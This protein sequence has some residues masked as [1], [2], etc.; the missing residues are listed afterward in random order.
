MLT[1]LIGFGA[2]CDQCWI[3][4]GVVKLEEVSPDR[5]K[6]RLWRA[7]RARHTPWDAPEG[8]LQEACWSG[9]SRVGVWRQRK[10]ARGELWNSCF[11]ARASAQPSSGEIPPG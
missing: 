10:R 11:L 3:I 8:N 4:A 5:Q 1:S 6:P 7:A 9:K 2:S